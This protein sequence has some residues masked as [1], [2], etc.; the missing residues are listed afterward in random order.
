MYIKKFHIEEFGP[1]ENVQA[2]NLPQT[3]AV[4]LGDNE[5]GKSSSMEFIRTMLT[6]IPNRRDLLS[7]NMKKFKGGSMLLD[8]E[9]Y[10]ELLVERNFSARSNRNLKVFGKNGKKID[11]A[12]FYKATDHISQ[13]VYRLV[14][15]FTLAELQNFSAFQDTGVFE[16]ILGASYG[17]GLVSPDIA[18]QKIR[19]KMEI[20]Y[21]SKGKNSVLQELFAKWKDEHSLFEQNAKRVEKFDELQNKLLTAKESYQELKQEKSHIKEKEA[22]LHKLLAL[23]G[24]WKKWADLQQEF[25]NMKAVGGSFFGSSTDNTKNSDDFSENSEILFAKILE[26]RRFKEEHAAALFLSMRECEA[27]LRKFHIKTALISQYQPIKDLAPLYLEAKKTLEEIPLQEVQAEQAQHSLAKQNAKVLDKWHVFNASPL[28]YGFDSPE[29]TLEHFAAVLGDDIFPEDLEKYAAK[30]R[31]AKN[32]AQNAETALEYAKRDVDKAA[33]KYEAV[34]EEKNSQNS[35]SLT[36]FQKNSLLRQEDID[37]E[38]DLQIWQNRLQETKEKENGC[39]DESAV[40]CAEFLNQAKNLGFTSLKDS[41]ISKENAKEFLQVYMQLAQTVATARKNEQKLSDLHREYTDLTQKARTLQEESER[42]KKQPAA[43][44]EQDKKRM[45]KIRAI[46]KTIP[47]ILNQLEEIRQKSHAAPQEKLPKFAHIP[48][49]ACFVFGIAFLLMRLGSTGASVES[50]AGTLNI[51]LFL[52]VLLLAA[53]A[54]LEGFFHILEK[55]SVPE[56]SDTA[57]EKINTLMQDLQ[58]LLDIEEK[59][60]QTFYPEQ[61]QNRGQNAQNAEE[62]SG[63]REEFLQ[64]NQTLHEKIEEPKLSKLDRIIEKAKERASLYSHYA[65]SFRFETDSGTDINP[66]ETESLTRKAKETEN[67]IKACMADLQVNFEDTE[68]LPAFF[69][70]IERLDNLVQEINALSIRVRDCRTV[71]EDFLL[72]IKNTL[73]HL[74]EKFSS[75]P[76]GEYLPAL[77]QY[78]QKVRDEQ[79]ARI[80][81]LHGAIFAQSLAALE[82][83]REHCQNVEKTL[84]E[85]K[86]HLKE[87]YEELAEFLC[88]TGFLFKDMQK[89]FVELLCA[90]EQEQDILSGAFLSVRQCTEALYRLHALHE[91]QKQ[92]RTHI[93]NLHGRLKEF[94]DPLRTVLMRSEFSPK[95]TIREDKDYIQVYQ[96]L[97][98]ELEQEYTLFGQKENLLA[99]Y[100]ETQKRCQKAE[101]EVQEVE[102]ALQE[103]YAAANV[104]DEEALKSLFAKIKESERYIQQAVILEESLRE[105]KCPR[106]VEKSRHPVQREYKKLPDQA[107]LP[108]IFSFFD[109]NAKERFER[110]LMELSEEDAGLE[111]IEKHIRELTAKVEAES[112]AL[113]EESLSNEAGYRMKKTEEEIK[114]KYNEWLE[115]AFAAE[116][117]ERAKKQ[118][119]ENSQPEIVRIASEFFAQITDGAWQDIKVS[120]EDRSVRVLDESKKALPAEMLSQGA[121]EQLYLSLRLAHIRH[122]SLTKQPLPLLMDDILVNFDEKRMKN[123]AKVLNLMVRETLDMHSSQ[124]ILYYTCHE[125]TAQILLETVQN[126]KLFHVRD[127]KIFAG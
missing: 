13:D 113:Y 127:K 84:A 67:K 81:N 15:G 97:C 14:F 57:S 21:K 110:E 36:D 42:R 94:T 79:F 112:S 99:E 78:R 120:L 76:A 104:Q 87:I 92:R 35:D 18:L 106:F 20:L 61:I 55:K 77:T 98:E 89:K 12:V 11:N 34:L 103:L 73:P 52:P 23:W 26:Q 100:E 108:E 49:A 25:I 58:E 1:L 48:S 45:E 124:Q 80:Q 66:D 53:G 17:L 5:A 6:G 50:F 10:G 83:S 117:L 82:E 60:L 122:R 47:N 4:F 123:T 70:S 56:T 115:F 96:D 105:E 43:F 101:Q 93:Q 62:H 72:W 39:L 126:A 46:E 75:L 51:P 3:M 125:R 64:F 118:Y 68:K 91:E 16:N 119:E 65:N 40:K 32:H 19:E 31:D 24:Q 37:F 28:V 114:A 27:K 71:Y 85:R 107:E 90:E 74:F 102:K 8:D 63:S 88:K 109:E 59:L 121:K 33:R 41:T 69:K 30:I 116:I 22:E 44:T 86:S 95:E 29:L 111:R 54:G 7:Q 2:D 9:K 38:Q